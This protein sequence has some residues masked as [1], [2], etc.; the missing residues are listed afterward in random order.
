MTTISE[1]ITSLWDE[2]LADFPPTHRTLQTMLS[3]QAERYGDRV[4]YEFAGQQ[5]SYSQAINVAARGA[6]TLALLGIHPGDRVAIMCGNKAEFFEIFLGAA[7]LGAIAVPL[8]VA[9]KGSQLEH[10]LANSGAALIACEEQYV[11]RFET[12]D[13]KLTSLQRVVLLDAA[14]VTAQSVP[15]CTISTWELANDEAPAGP[16]N[17]SDPLAILYTS[18][19]TG[20]SKGVLCT[21]AQ[22]FWWGYHSANILEIS[23]G[24]RL[25][26]TLPVFHTNALSTFFQALLTG[27]SAFFG[28]KFSASGFLSAIQ[29]T[30]A[31][32]TYLL[33]AMVPIL[34]TTP[35]NPQDTNHN[36]RVILAPGVP[37]KDAQAFEERFGTTLI[38]GFAST[39]SNF[40]IGAQ[41]S[42]RKPGTM[43]KLRPGFSAKIVDEFE[44]SVPDGT[45]GELLL[46]ADE[47]NTFAAGYYEMPEKTV[48]AWQDLWLHTG[49]RV[50]RDEDGY[51]I[52][53]DRIKDVIR[54]RGEN[55]SS[56][57]VEQAIGSHPA[58]ESAAVFPVRSDLAEDEVM[59][60]VV[61]RKGKTLDPAELIDHCQPLI[62]YFA[63][64][65]YVDFVSSLPM[66]ENGKV[67]KFML[68]EE[69]VTPTTWDR[70]K[71]GYILAR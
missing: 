61:L 51:Y 17:A 47:A 23:E 52:F 65:R 57:E 56:F 68:R 19:T 27:S 36:L 9:L 6:H 3:H 13:L 37:A 55:I 1:Q 46:R 31:N 14:S 59:V 63:V 25:H 18:G 12:I 5:I 15:G 34:L 53:R 2:L 58:V 60:S 41:A 50:V 20:V 62:S 4:L 35:P 71:S 44:T 10:M 33:G 42:E 28:A 39:E 26:T 30:K 22:Y 40:V 7:W 11:S 48:E 69:G 21:H 54:R 8:N 38:D 66:T 45:P 16:S 49:D 43:G 67:R 70:D 32:I 29:S 24:E 64:P